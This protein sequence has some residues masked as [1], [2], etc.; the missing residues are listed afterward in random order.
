MYKIL[1]QTSKNPEEMPLKKNDLKVWHK[2]EI[3]QLPHILME[4]FR[5]L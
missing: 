2:A 1:K 3:M 5:M 4:N